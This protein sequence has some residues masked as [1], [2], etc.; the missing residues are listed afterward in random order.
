M[1]RARARVFKDGY[2]T[3]PAGDP[4]QLWYVER[5]SDGA[6]RYFSNGVIA[7]FHA[8]RLRRGMADFDADHDFEQLP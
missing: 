7:S 4:L 1:T 3:G 8:R 2:R 5:Q 6:R